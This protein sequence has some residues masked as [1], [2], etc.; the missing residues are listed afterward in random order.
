MET[1]TMPPEQLLHLKH[2]VCVHLNRE[3]TQSCSAK[4]E[5]DP[6][7]SRWQKIVIIFVVF[8]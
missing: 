3:V 1:L 2:A 6:L 5:T 7:R 8:F 4:T